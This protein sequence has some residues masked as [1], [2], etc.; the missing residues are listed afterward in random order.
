MVLVDAR[1]EYVD[2]RTTKAEVDAFSAA[3]NTQ[4]T[5]YAVARRL[6]IARLF[7]ASL[8]DQPL[9]PDD[10]ATEMA[11]LQTGPAAIEETTLEGLA[12]A[13]D[14]TELANSTLGSTPLVVIAASES[15]ENTPNWTGAQHS[16]AALSTKAQLV[17]AE[18]SG[19]YVQLQQP[20]VVIDAVRN[21]VADVRKQP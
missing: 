11:L 4:A 6:G 9:V 2:A 3:L 17:V 7:G 1:S 20:N 19:H 14:D 12:R 13:A 16:L 18:P 15:L 5:V 8:V 10:T 21:V